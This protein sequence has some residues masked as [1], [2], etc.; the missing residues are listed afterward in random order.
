M[1]YNAA[2]QEVH[3][4]VRYLYLFLDIIGGYDEVWRMWTT[5]NAVADLA[6][7]NEVNEYPTGTTN[8]WVYTPTQIRK[9]DLVSTL[10]TFDFTAG[11]TIIFAQIYDS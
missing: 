11:H 7:S 2:K 5:T 10:R 1:G 9:F 4:Q 8:S 3:L 6:I